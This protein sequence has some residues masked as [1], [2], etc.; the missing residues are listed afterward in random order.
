MKH[1][2]ILDHL[3]KAY[4]N[5]TLA[6]NEVIHAFYDPNAPRDILMDVTIEKIESAIKNVRSA[7][8]IIND[9]ERNNETPYPHK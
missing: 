8:D 9:L 3:I 6:N 2:K 4:I 5:L 7:V 1:T